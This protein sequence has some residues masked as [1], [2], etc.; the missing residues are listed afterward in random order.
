M[1]DDIFQKGTIGKKKH[2]QTNKQTTNSNLYRKSLGFFRA[3]EGNLILPTASYLGQLISAR[4][5]VIVNH[6]NLVAFSTCSVREITARTNN[7]L[8]EY[9]VPKGTFLPYN[10]STIVSSKV[11]LP[12]Q[13]SSFDLLQTQLL[14]QASCFPQIVVQVHECYAR[15][16]SGTDV[17]NLREVLLQN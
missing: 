6:L 15:R 11:L 2:N 12:N 1:S 3:K 17:T 8:A 5:S 14:L 10:R 9:T 13:D 4:G 16:P 7:M